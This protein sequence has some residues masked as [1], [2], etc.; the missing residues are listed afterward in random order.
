MLND[1]LA[2][3]LLVTVDCQ[4]D[5]LCLFR[6]GLLRLGLHLSWLCRLCLCPCWLLRLDRL[7][8]VHIIL[9]GG[10][11]QLLH[12][13]ISFGICHRA[14]DSLVEAVVCT[15]SRP[16]VLASLSGVGVVPYEAE[17]HEDAVT[18]LLDAFRDD[19]LCQC[20]TQFVHFRTD[21]SEE[22]GSG[23]ESVIEVL[24]FG[25]LVQ[26]PDGLL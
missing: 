4:S 2:Q 20:E 15:V 9:I 23:D 21:N 24:V 3:A 6:L 22:L 13:V 12:D 11:V 26:G 8:A 1:G 10:D 17:Q 16:K 19:S 5:L 7:H 25:V 18:C 14:A